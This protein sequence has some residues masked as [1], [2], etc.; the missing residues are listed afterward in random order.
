MQIRQ[1]L[2]MTALAILPW[3]ASAD[4]VPKVHRDAHRQMQTQLE[5][6]LAFQSLVDS[7]LNIKGSAKDEDAPFDLFPALDLYGSW[8]DDHVD[9]LAG[10]TG[11]KIPETAD[12]NLNGFVAPI[13]GR[14]NS[15][16]GWRRRRP[17]KGIDV[18]L[19]VGDTVRA[20]FD[21]QVRIRKFDRR[22]Y[23]YYYVIRHSNGLET[24]YGHLS[25]HIVQQGEMVRAG[26][27]IGL[28]GSTGRSTGPHLHFEFRYL[29]VPINPAEV[30]NLDDFTPRSDTY[31]FVYRNAANAAYLSP[32]NRQGGRATASSAASAAASAS[33]ANYHR[34]KKGDTL[35]AIARK[36]GTTVAKLCRLNGIRSTSTLQLGQKIRYR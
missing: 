32:S 19:F 27:A 16:F 30:L 23:G 3:T 17:H 18:H 2:I 25:K 12:I 7:V 22:G 13:V 8:D 4:L 29:G 15:P 33:G 1:I 10:K 11:I 35:G 24:V 34:V 6:T 26:Q 14:I 21:G 31:H 28:G 36:Y 20:A 5:N 9:P